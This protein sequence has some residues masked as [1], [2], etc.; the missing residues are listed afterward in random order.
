M[1]AVTVWP[2]KQIYLNVYKKSPIAL[3]IFMY[4]SFQILNF[5]RHCFLYHVKYFS[6]NEIKFMTLTTLMCIFFKN[7]ATTQGNIDSGPWVYLAGF[8]VNFLVCLLVGLLTL[9]NLRIRW[10]VLLKTYEN[11][12]RAGK[13]ANIT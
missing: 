10:L 8:V 4:R 6:C 2:A 7:S 9:K 3:T 1:D 13:I 11:L 5:S 12:H